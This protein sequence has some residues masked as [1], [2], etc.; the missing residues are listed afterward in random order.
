[1]SWDA[2]ILRIRG[3]V[4]PVADLP[5]SNCLLSSVGLAPSPSRT[6]LA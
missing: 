1:M 6:E 2:I 4:R 5:A 3:A